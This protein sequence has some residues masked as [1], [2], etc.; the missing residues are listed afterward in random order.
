MEAKFDFAA[1]AL[2]LRSAPPPQSLVRVALHIGGDGV[3]ARPL[4]MAEVLALLRAHSLPVLRDYLEH[5]VL[6]A[7]VTDPGLHTELILQLCDAA[8]Q[9]MPSIDTRH[10]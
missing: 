1:S 6:E 8:L 9:L 7:Q 5:L 10:A 2:H 4:N 3:Q